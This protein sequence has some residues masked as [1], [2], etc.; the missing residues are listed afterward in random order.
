MLSD[1]K[2]R[3]KNTETKSEIGCITTDATEV[4]MLSRDYCKQ[5]YI[6][7]FCSPEETHFTVQ[8]KQIL[9][10]KRNKLLGTYCLLRLS[11]KETENLSRPIT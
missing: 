3:E 9:Q 1:S 11:H 7:K 6:N 2:K 8:K 10:S 5:L 4:K